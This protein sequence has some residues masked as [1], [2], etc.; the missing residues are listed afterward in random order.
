MAGRVTSEIGI[1]DAVAAVAS[2][3]PDRPAVVADRGTLTFG[4]L[5]ARAG[6][7]AERLVRAGLPRQSVVGVHLDRVPAAVVALLAVL[8]AGAVHLPLEPRHPRARLRYLLADSG[9]RCVITDAPDRDRARWPVELVPAQAE[10]PAGWHAH[11]AVHP[12]ELA[13][14]MYTSGTTG[15]PKA[16]EVTHGN[17]MNLL[18]GLDATVWR[19][20]GPARV[21][22]NASP[23]FDA[24]VQQWIRLA[25][26][27]TVV[28]VDEEDRADPARFLA[29]LAR[30]GVT[31]LDVVP[32]HLSHLAERMEAAGMP[33][34]LL[35]GGEPITP[36]LWEWLVRMAGSHGV[37]AWNVYGPTE[38][39]VDST[40]TVVAGGS[41]HLG[42]PLPGVRAYLLDARLAPVPGGATGELFIAGAGV[43]RGYRGRPGRTASAFLPD[44]VAGDGTR[45]Y[46]TGDLVRRGD[47]GRIEYVRRRDRQVKVRGHRVELGEIEAALLA[48]PA[49]T[50]AV[51]VLSDAL[52]AGSGI[53]AYLVLREAVAQG[54]LRRALAEHLPRYM[55]PSAFVVLDAL[56]TGVTGKVDCSALPAPVRAGHG[57]AAA[58]G[59][60]L[61]RRIAGTWCEVLNREDVGV[62]DDFFALGGDSLTVAR[63]LNRCRE[64]LGVAMKPRDLFDHPVL[65]DFAGVVRRELDRLV[66]SGSEGLV[67][68]GS[69]G[70]A[71]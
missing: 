41:P 61:E 8:K 64:R 13:Y 14:V 32:S 53:V 10:L 2:T 15:R 18:R 35:V 71:P 48:L 36:A 17:V 54:A 34:R 47:D 25:R 20:L 38:C 55:L 44:V 60:A 29:R 7:L 39:T 68:S 9:A 11:R 67:P 22:W 24:S 51:A 66:P 62:D 5:N 52:P 3:H 59:S 16:V 69:E 58:P 33:L 40:T 45:M 30:H 42:A 28:L 21:A 63:V 70:V 43:S 12:Q 31:D 65:R 49:V 46:R 1:H 50:S 27:D 23:S 56:P 4:E 19:G 6:R 57:A 26:G 37:R